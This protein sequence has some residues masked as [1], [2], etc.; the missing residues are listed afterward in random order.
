MF[1]NLFF[2]TLPL[3]GLVFIG[4]SLGKFSLFN[5]T[6]AKV[7]T[8]LVGLVVLPAL[9]IK[10]IGNFNY[11]FINWKLYFCYLLGQGIIY[12]IAF[13][14]AK[15]FFNRSTPECIIIGLVSSSSNHLFFIYPIVLVEFAAK[16]I[17]PIETVIAADFITVGLSVCALDFT[18]QNKLDIKN[19]VL[20]QIKNPAFIGL[21]LGLIIYHSSINLPESSNRLVDFI[22]ASGVPLT[23]LA[24]GILLSYKTD[25]TQIQLSFLITF[26]KLFGFLIVLTLIIWLSEIS[27]ADAKTTLMLSATPIGA[28]GLV[29]ASIY[30]VKTDAVVRSGL[31]TYIIA[32]FLIP[33]VGS[34]F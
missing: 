29:F 8:K 27:F 26:L 14:I 12:F 18:T 25:S 1:S 9:G 23:L 33:L 7:F 6:E 3:F 10:I 2:S 20:K 15:K 5:D 30:K 28:M 22:C 32:L 17:V 31:L 24:M 16:D 19:A 21:I 4:Y 13:I 34:V 11:E